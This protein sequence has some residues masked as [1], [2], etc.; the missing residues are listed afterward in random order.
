MHQQFLW[1]LACIVWGALDTVGRPESRKLRMRT[2]GLNQSSRLFSAVSCFLP[3]CTPCVLEHG[4]KSLEVKTIYF[5]LCLWKREVRK[6]LV[7][8]WPLHKTWGSRLPFW[9]VTPKIWLFR[10]QFSFCMG[11]RWPMRREFA[12]GRKDW[13]KGHVENM[14]K[15]CGNSILYRWQ[16]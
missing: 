16:K 15:L 6:S 1:D 3:S 13:S 4:F 11:C 12:W 8:I 10:K 7:G 14:R 9:T 5:V 2:D